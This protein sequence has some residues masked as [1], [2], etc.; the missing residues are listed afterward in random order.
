MS[1]NKASIVMVIFL[2]SLMSFSLLAADKQR[3]DQ[4]LKLS[5]KFIHQNT[6]S[7]N[8][9][10]TTLKESFDSFSDGQKINWFVLSMNVATQQNDLRQVNALIEMS[11]N[12]LPANLSA[13]NHWLKVLSFNALLL[14]R[15]GDKLLSEIQK[16]ESMI[17]NQADKWLI[18]YFNRFHYHAY[19]IKGSWDFALDT[20]LINRK[21]WLELDEKYFALETLVNISRCQIQL[22]DFVGAGTNIK[23]AQKQSSNMDLGN[24]KIAL[25]ELEAKL[26]LDQRKPQQAFAILNDLVLKNEVA[27]GHDRYF[28][29]Q[30]K[31]ALIDFKLMKYQEAIDI[32]EMLLGLQASSDQNINVQLQMLLAR[33]LVKM[34]QY[35]QAEEIVK[36]SELVYQSQND[37]FGLFEVDQ[38]YIDI[39]FQQKNYQQMYQR[40]QKLID[41]VQYYDDNL[42]KKRVERAQ[43]VATVKEKVK[44]LTLSEQLIVTKNRSLLLLTLLCALLIIMFFWLVVLLKKV[45]HLANIDSLTNISNRRF[46]LEQAKKR[47]L[48]QNVKSSILGISIID[49]DYFKGINDTY[50]H[51][52]GDKVL[53]RTVNII[54]QQL[55]AK[56]VFCRMGGEEFLLVLSC[57]NR[58]QLSEKLNHIRQ[59]ICQGTVSDIGL[60]KP[61]T[62]SL[63]VAIAD[64]YSKTLTDYIIEADTALYQAKDSG[65]NCVSFYQP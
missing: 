43:K 5:E 63:G 29:V 48:K 46:G 60:V 61:V 50:G 22:W 1:C 49:L 32:V 16:I 4:S 21:E 59:C 47:L 58:Q 41:L 3:I 53:Q 42:A 18:A 7:A 2:F 57:V 13:R 45:R 30:F 55:Q 23:E 20:A 51:D 39:F 62:I 26:L 31:L 56:D 33:S 25:K 17:D 38:I 65:R 15:K 11:N 54:K 37:P 12:L 64:S 34:G 36:K 10:L 40:T 14:E 27:I 6:V 52:T 9:Q 19:S 44:A 35:T 28:H 24:I 8:E